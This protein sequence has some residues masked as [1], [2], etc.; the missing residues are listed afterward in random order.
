MFGIGLIL[1]Y[2]ATH[3][4]EAK[5]RLPPEEELPPFRPEAWRA[6]AHPVPGEMPA[7]REYRA[8]SD[9]PDRISSP[10]PHRA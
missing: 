4:I 8:V 1:L 3:R 10:L 9:E 2:N 6:W 5:G 7:S